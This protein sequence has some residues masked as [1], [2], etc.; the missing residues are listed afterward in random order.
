[1]N[2]VARAVTI[3]V[4]VVCALAT[5]TSGTI[6]DQEV[7]PTG[8]AVPITINISQDG[9]L[10]VA[11]RDQGGGH[12]RT[13]AALK[14]V[15]QGENTLTWDGL[16]DEGKPVRPGEYEVL[17]LLS[18]VVARFMGY[19]G[20]G[21]IPKNDDWYPQNGATVIGLDVDDEGKYIYVCYDYGERQ[22]HIAKYDTEG[23]LIWK[24][25]RGR[26]G[27]LV[28]YQGRVYRACAL[29]PD[30][31]QRPERFVDIIEVCDAEAGVNVVVQEWAKDLTGSRPHPPLMLGLCGVDSRG[32]PDLDAFDGRL[33]IPLYWEDR[34]S[35]RD[36]ATFEEVESITQVPQPKGIAVGPWGLAAVAADEVWIYDN[37]CNFVRAICP[38]CQPW[39]LDADAAGNLYVTELGGA[40]RVA[41]RW[42]PQSGWISHHYIAREGHVNRVIKVSLDGKIQ[43]ARGWMGPLSGDVVPEKLFG[44][45]SVAVGGQGDYYIGEFFLNRLRAFDQEGTERWQIDGNAPTHPDPRDPTHIWWGGNMSQAGWGIIRYQV[46]L[47]TMEYKPDRWYGQP[48]VTGPYPV[49]STI[50]W[51][52]VYD[53]YQHQ[54]RTYVQAGLP[55]AYQSIFDVTDADNPALREVPMRAFLGQGFTLPRHGQRSI[56]YW[57]WWVDQDGNQRP[58]PGE[59]E[60]LEGITAGEFNFVAPGQLMLYVNGG[61]DNWR[62]R[63]IDLPKTGLTPCGSPRFQPDLNNTVME[64]DPQDFFPAQVCRDSAGNYYVR[65]SRYGPWANAI[66]PHTVREDFVQIRKYSKGMRELVWAIGHKARG[67]KDPGE[68]YTGHWFTYK[69]CLLE[70]EFLFTGDASG[71]VDVITHDGLWAGLLLAD[72]HLNGW[73]FEVDPYNLGGG[74]PTH[75]GVYRLGDR[76]VWCALEAG[77]HST[78]LYEITG[79][80]DLQR[81]RT[82]VRLT[83]RA[84]PLPA[85]ANQEEAVY[86]VTARLREG[87]RRY[88]IEGKLSEWRLFSP[89]VLEAE[90]VPTA[91]FYLRYDA[92]YLYVALEAFGDPNPAMN[93]FARQ[94]AFVTSWDGT[95]IELFFCTDPEM[96]AHLSHFTDKHFQ[97]FIPFDQQETTNQ[98]TLRQA[99]EV[100]GWVEGSQTGFVIL[101]REKGNWTAE[102]A[103]PWS[104]FPDFQPQ[105]GMTYHANLVMNWGSA[106]RTRAFQ[107]FWTPG[108]SRS[109]A[110]PAEWRGKLELGTME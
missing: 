46:D 68:F 100:I 14:E 74:E 66:G 17:W 42:I 71:Q 101:D 91:K 39:A 11:L 34:I 89:V 30:S 2:R 3:L 32:V 56:P 4:L 58:D 26:N 84:T 81:G 9:K 93:K 19:M 23:N 37:D 48:T 10:S 53:V 61:D 92:Q 31:R 87:D 108:S 55:Y 20:N 44:P 41:E 79:L 96:P 70:D 36:L 60:I 24:G 95:A 27:P 77:V 50:S 62:N 88:A 15:M 43:W 13:L 38:F 73:A 80:D 105:P 47:D 75:L 64:Y 67:K 40:H 29:Q 12:L 7:S 103:I 82:S 33:F 107:T 78:R 5:V 6:A 8:V 21:R 49:G 102:V 83:Q 85:Q 106:G 54:G 51:P 86:Q 110:S 63:L 57:G 98:V 94:D 22:D 76:V 72:G 25:G 45:I 1:M 35:I 97:F 59:Y 52:S 109:F 65:A 90:D 28:V 99:N 104:C 69:M 16:D 18:N